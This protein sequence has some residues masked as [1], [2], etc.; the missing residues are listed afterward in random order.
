VPP[1]ENLDHSSRQ[2]T[3]WEYLWA[4]RFF[5]IA[6]ILALALR[7]YPETKWMMWPLNLFGTYIHELFHGIF[8]ILGGGSFKEMFLWPGGGGVSYNFHYSTLGRALGAMGGLIGP[9]I[10]GAI[11]LF[12]SRRFMLT[13]WLL[14]GLS[15]SV[16]LSA[17]YWG[18][19]W[20]TMQIGLIAGGIIGA[21]S[22]IP[23][24]PA[25]RI[26][27][28]FLAIQLCFEN[29]LDFDYMFSQGFTRDGV[30]YTSDTANIAEAMGGTYW[31][32]GAIISAITIAIVVFAIVK[33]KPKI[34]TTYSAD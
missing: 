1:I 12:F 23:Y 22:F 21:V 31:F 6:V 16:I 5:W 18:G 20:H 15:L 24:K 27:A 19:D 26:F 25:I 7:F 17:A 11:I 32:W 9:C 14:K 2:P 33:S 13:H 4:D 29:L 34:V 28:Q 3:L 8:A 10:I 30:A